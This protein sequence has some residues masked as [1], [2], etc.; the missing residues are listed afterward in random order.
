MLLGGRTGADQALA[1]KRSAS[2]A[3]CQFKSS[4]DRHTA[5]IGDGGI[6][7]HESR[8]CNPSEGP[9]FSFRVAPTRDTNVPR[10]LLLVSECVGTVTTA[11]GLARV[12]VRFTVRLRSDRSARRIGRAG[13]NARRSIGGKVS[14]LIS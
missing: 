3:T 4:L 13:M 10:P 9:V 8:T 5:I 2:D 12:C 7:T 6:R 11:H 1:G 14:R